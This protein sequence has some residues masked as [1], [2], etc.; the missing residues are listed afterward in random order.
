[1][2]LGIAAVK[3]N[4]ELWQRSFFKNIKSVV[5]IGSQELHL[6]QADFEELLR[7]A[8]VTTYKKENFTPL[9]N[10]PGQ[11]RCSAKPFYEMLG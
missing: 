5:D 10:W 7:V 11:P 1:M 3:L 9:A 6:K 2:G 8:G 4:L